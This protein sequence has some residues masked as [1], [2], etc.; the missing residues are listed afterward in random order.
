MKTDANNEHTRIDEDEPWMDENH[1]RIEEKKMRGFERRNENAH[2][3]HQIKNARSFLKMQEAKAQSLTF[4][5]H[6]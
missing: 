3:Y 4:V 2:S 1:A 5:L 6:G